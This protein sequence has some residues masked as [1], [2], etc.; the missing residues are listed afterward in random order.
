[1]HIARLHDAD[2]R[3][4]HVLVRRELHGCRGS[5]TMLIHL[6]LRAQLSRRRRQTVAQLATTGWST[7]TTPTEAAP[8]GAPSPLTASLK[9]S[10][11]MGVNC[12]HSGGTSSS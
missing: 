10:A 11:L 9:N 6:G 1:M 12:F 4:V 2:D 3:S 7:A 8:P 5:M